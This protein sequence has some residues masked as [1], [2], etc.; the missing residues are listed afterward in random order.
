MYSRKIYSTSIAA[1]IFAGAVL[2]LTPQLEAATTVVI[3]AVDAQKRPGNSGPN[4]LGVSSTSFITMVDG[5]ETNITFTA[6]TGRIFLGNALG[7]IMGITGSPANATSAIES[8]AS[9]ILTISLT[10]TVATWIT[11]TINSG[12]FIGG[13]AN[14]NAPTLSFTNAS[15]SVVYA[16]ASVGFETSSG[17]LPFSTPPSGVDSV[18]FTLRQT[19]ETA[20]TS[21]GGFLSAFTVTATAIPEPS[22]AL[23]AGLSVLALHRRRRLD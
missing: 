6:S 8:R 15:G 20:D 4:D 13:G 3:S 17:T 23:L 14:S 16:S 22:S 12:V 5:I 21:E 18:S 1:V 10:P 9:E 11:Y 19:A 7:G 2:G